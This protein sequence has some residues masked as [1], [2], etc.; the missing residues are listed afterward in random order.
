M[1]FRSGGRHAYHLY[2]VRSPRRDLLQCHLQR[3][4]IATIV[5]YPTPVHRQLA[6][7]ALGHADGS[8]PEAERAC[9]EVLS[10]PLYPELTEA[11]LRRVAD[12][13]RSAR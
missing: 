9:A 8:F 1:L 6:Y 13:V 3:H 5:H 12:A 4:G 2:V 10:L 7:L 11:E